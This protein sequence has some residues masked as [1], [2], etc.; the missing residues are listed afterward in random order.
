MS[1]TQPMDNRGGNRP[2]APQN[3]PMNVNPF[4]GNGQSGN[5]DYS[6]F[7][8]GMNKQINEQRQ[9]AP[10][11]TP[12]P[13]PTAG[14]M[15]ASAGPTPIGITEPTAYPEQD[16]TTPADIF[17]PVV[18]PE[19]ADRN[20]NRSI[21]SYAPQFLYIANQPD[22]SQETRDTLAMLLRYTQS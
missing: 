6:G 11:A 19:Q 15:P 17:P 2:T 7:G 13:R 21:Q 10:I 12:T 18:P 16:V 5:I 8:Y 14:A 4:G 9:A 22:T 20:F 3:N 1:M